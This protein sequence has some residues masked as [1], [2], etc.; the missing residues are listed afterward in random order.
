MDTNGKL[1]GLPDP[2][3]DEAFEMVIRAIID[4]YIET[5]AETTNRI[6]R[7]QPEILLAAIHAHRHEA[8]DALKEA[9]PE[10]AYLSVSTALYLAAIE[11]A[12]MA[13]AEMASKQ[14]VNAEES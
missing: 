7:A 14:G 8:M 4:G 11:L 3:S 2:A 5:E 13:K 6:R 10:K 1:G 12:K 9:L